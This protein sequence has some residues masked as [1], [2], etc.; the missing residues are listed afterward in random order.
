MFYIFIVEF[1]VFD[2]FRVE[3]EIFRVEFGVFHILRVE[4][5][6]FRVTSKLLRYIDVFGVY[7]V[8]RGLSF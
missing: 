3:P 6:M 8:S 7:C 2:L 4:S 5:E 1:E